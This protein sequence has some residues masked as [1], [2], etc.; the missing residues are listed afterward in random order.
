VFTSCAYT[1]AQQPAEPQSTPYSLQ[2]NVNRVLVPVVVRDKQGHAVS[3][4]KK[5][6]FQVFDR[7]KP[8]AIS[9]FTVQQR[10]VLETVTAASAGAGTGPQQPP[11]ANIAIE[12]A[13][14]PQR[15]MIFLFDDLNL[16][17][18]DLVPVK[19]AGEKAMA[20]LLAPSDMA[21]VVSTSGQITSPLTQD[22][23]KL[24]AA[25]KS[26]SPIAPHRLEFGDGCTKI[27]YFEADQIIN[28]P[29]NGVLQLALAQA[30]ACGIGSA[31]S[32]A[33][34][35]SGPN[36]PPPGSNTPTSGPGSSGSKSSGAKSPPPPPQNPCLDLTSPD[37]EFC[38]A[39]SPIFSIAR[40]TLQLGRQNVLST[41]ATIQA[42]VR[43][44]ATL[45]PGQRVLILVSPGTLPME[46]TVRS[47][48]SET[49]NL[50]AASNVTI[51]TIDGRGLYADSAFLPAS[52][53][54]LA[55]TMKQIAIEQVLRHDRALVA[56]LSMVDLANATGGTAFQ[57]S[58]DMDAGFKKVMEVPECVYELEISLDGMKPDGIYHRLNVKVDR[59]GV[60]VTA[61][62]G[63]FMSKPQKN[64]K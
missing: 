4:L 8:H 1:A 13:A 60:D 6:D 59:K 30:G 45:P 57:N 52:E 22:R 62:P 33:S 64:K 2:L 36:T 29:E 5:E 56:G 18:E 23:A 47:V 26:L 17:F 55:S 38:P 28:H 20:D 63:Y 12:P 25:I 14:R 24:Q 58:N 16:K 54:E 35:S 53:R 48:E 10:G 32:S 44:M 7:D 40:Q 15:Y 49:M 51:N 21:A 27:D 46:D 19:K 31:G 41:Y 34:S 3:D 11:P 37:A 50:A 43:K 42:F 9:G 61:R 39:L